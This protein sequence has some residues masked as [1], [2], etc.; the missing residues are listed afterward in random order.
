MRRMS[1]GRAWIAID[2]DRCSFCHGL[3]HE[4]GRHAAPRGITKS[5]LLDAAGGAIDKA[6][7]RGGRCLISRGRGTTT[8]DGLQWRAGLGDT[9]AIVYADSLIGS[10]T[11]EDSCVAGSGKERFVECDCW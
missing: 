6:F 1:T 5:D 10:K 8:V 4:A 2:Y 11:Q 7:E 9:R 3:R